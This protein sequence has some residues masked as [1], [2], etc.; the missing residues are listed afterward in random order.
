MRLITKKTK[1]KAEEYVKKMDDKVDE[2]LKEFKALPSDYF[3]TE[4]EIH[5]YF[6]HKCLSDPVFFDGKSFNYV[7]AEYPTPF[8]CR[9]S[10]DKLIKAPDIEN[11]AMRSHVDMVFINPN[12]VT[13]IKKKS[14]D[15]YI[16]YLNGITGQVFSVYIKDLVEKFE[17]FYN[18]FKEPVL[19]YAIEFKYFRHRSSG[20]ESPVT[21]VKYD[22]SKLKLLQNPEFESLQTKFPFSAK[23]LSIVLFTRNMNGLKV[24]IEKKLK[25]TEKYMRIAMCSV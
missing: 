19:I 12:F 15:D 10:K 7:H 14:K 3:F 9:K 16:K 13:W 11:H 4:K 6:Y 5:A 22:V 8:K 17:E 25:G 1:M 23:T 24:E 21:D 18:R 2:F 20:K